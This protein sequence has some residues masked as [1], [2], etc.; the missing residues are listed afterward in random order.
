MKG[1]KINLQGYQFGT[2]KDS[3]IDNAFRN[4]Q[5]QTQAVIFEVEIQDEV[6]YFNIDKKEYNPYHETENSIIL[7]DGA[8]YQVDS[9][10]KEKIKIKNKN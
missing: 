7:L 4:I 2:N 8:A 1:E 5:K 3:A 6:N 10:I 9:Y